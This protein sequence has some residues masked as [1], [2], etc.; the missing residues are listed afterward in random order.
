MKE[1][2]IGLGSN[3]GDRLENIQKAIEK[4]GDL[5]HTKVVDISPL[6]QSR[7]FGFES[8]NYFINCA[9]KIQTDLSPLDLLDGLLRIERDMGRIRKGNGYT[10][11][12]I[13]LDILIYNSLVIRDVRLC[14]P[15]PKIS[16]RLFVLC[17]LM[18][19]CSDL[20][21]PDL[22]VSI[23]K[24]YKK[25]LDNNLIKDRPIRIDYSCV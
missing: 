15:H 21:L 11:R 20:I 2:Y 4:I 5:P 7:P 6:Y 16:E 1:V 25:A 3:L 18:D 13:D 19:L 17:P 14:I 12:T 23:E 10:D 24:L 9:I 22:N 8:E